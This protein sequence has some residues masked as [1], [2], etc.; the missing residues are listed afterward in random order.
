MDR[1]IKIVIVI[2]VANFLLVPF[3]SQHYAYYMP[4]THD[5]TIQQHGV[6]NGTRWGIELF[7]YQYGVP[8][9]LS[10]YYSFGREITLNLP[11]GYYHYSPIS[12]SGYESGTG[13]VDFHLSSSSVAQLSVLKFLKLY[14]LNFDEAGLPANSS[15]SVTVNGPQGDTVG[16]DSGQEISFM[17]P[18]GT[19]MYKAAQTSGK[20][21][22]YPEFPVAVDKEG[23]STLTLTPSDN[24]VNVF[25]TNSTYPVT[26][27]ISANFHVNNGNIYGIGVLIDGQTHYSHFNFSSYSYSTISLMLP[28]GIYQYATPNVTG[29][30]IGNDWG[31]IKVENAPANTTIYYRYSSQNIG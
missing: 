17:V 29:Y 18:A 5:F 25:F 13:G 15:W 10:N 24:K 23:F 31:Y 22:K 27:N 6:A 30:S 7:D 3:I 28:D 16:A 21:L 8:K 4:K 19:Y 11:Y 26:V 12:P 2:L 14:S 20:N 9:E 1:Q